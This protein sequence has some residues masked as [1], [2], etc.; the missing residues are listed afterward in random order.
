MILLVSGAVFGTEQVLVLSCKSASSPNDTTE[1]ILTVLSREI[2]LR[3][4]KAVDDTSTCD[5]FDRAV[6]LGKRME[7]EDV[8]FCSYTASFTKI[9]LSLNASIRGGRIKYSEDIKGSSVSDLFPKISPFVDNYL[10]EKNTPVAWKAEDPDVKV[11]ERKPRKSFTGFSGNYSLFLPMGYTYTDHNPVNGFEITLSQLWKKTLW[12]FSGRSYTYKNRER[13]IA[14]NF[15]LNRTWSKRKIVFFA[16]GYVGVGFLYQLG[17]WDVDSD[18]YLEPFEFTALD[19]S[20]RAGIIIG[21]GYPLNLILRA[22]YDL[23]FV[24]DFYHGFNF[25]SGVVIWFME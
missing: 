13:F 25:S 5:N 23:S 17:Y 21:K 22:G 8:I 11:I 1:A 7:I 24:S 20:P 14:V 4:Y 2:N 9:N 6:E 19:I 18:E 10:S 3:G 12:E 15:G 16:G